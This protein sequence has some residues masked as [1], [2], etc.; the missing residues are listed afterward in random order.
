[1]KRDHLHKIKNLLLL[2]SMIKIMIFYCVSFFSFLLLKPKNLKLKTL[3]AFII[4]NLTFNIAL[5]QTYPVQISTQLIPPYSGYL[6]DYADPTAQNLKVI[7]QFND[8]TVPSY[9]LKLKFEIKGNG[10]SLVT[11]SIYNP[12]PLSLQPG[13]PL[14]LSGID[15]APYLSSNNLDFIGINQSQYEQRMALP[16]GYYSICVKAYDYYSGSPVQVS[17][18]ACAQGWFTLS[19]PPLLN[20]P[21]CNTVV[22]PLQPQNLLFSWTPVNL[23]SP[24]SA[25][26][27]SY[28]FELWEM[29]PDSTVNPNQLVQNTQPI[30]SQ[31]TTFNNL[32][33]GIADPPLN[34]YYKYAWRVRVIDGSGRDWFINNGFSQVCTFYYGSI[35]N[36]LG[37]NNG[38]KIQAEALDYTTGKATWT[39]QTIYNAYQFEVRKANTQN[40]FPYTTTSGNQQIDNLEPNNTY[41]C[42]VKGFGNDFNSEYSN[43]VQFTTPNA[44]T[45]NCDQTAPIYSLNTT[46]LTINKALPGITLRSGQFDI[47]IKTIEPSTNGLGWYKGSGYALMF[48]LLPVPVTF[49]NVFIDD[50]LRHQQGLIEAVTQG[51]KNW[52]V[53]FDIEDAEENA[54][55]TEGTLDSVY[56][57]G[58]Q[59]CYTTIQNQTPVC[60]TLDTTNKIT[61]IR[62][63]DGN[64]YVVNAGPPPT[65][66]GPTNYLNTSNDNLAASDTL[67]VEFIASP[68]Q[69]FGF[70]GKEYAAFIEGYEC[71]KLNNG[72]NYFVP[73]KS[74]GINQNDKVYA[75]CTINNLVAANLSFKTLGGAMLTKT[76]VNPTVFEITNIPANANCIYAWYN[77][78]KIGKLNVLSLNK[79]SKKLVLVPV[80]NASTLG[81]T[82][83]GLNAIYKQAN[84]TFTITTASN[85][86]FNLGNDGLQEADATLLKKYSLEM[87]ALRDAY[88]S[89]NSNYDKNAYYVFVVPNFSIPQLKGYMVRGRAVGFVKA[90][91]DAKTL[92][93]ELAHGAFGL[94]HTFPAIKKDSSNNLLDDANGIHLVKAQWAQI[95]NPGVIFNWLDD[96]EDG[97][98]NNTCHRGLTPTGKMFDDCFDQDGKKIN[99]VFRI[100]QGTGWITSLFHNQELYNWSNVQSKYVNSNAQKQITVN[101]KQKPQN[102]KVN[103]YRINA[104]GCSYQSTSIIWTSRD[105]NTVGDLQVRI[106]NKLNTNTL[107]D[108]DLFFNVKNNTCGTGSGLEISSCPTFPQNM[109]SVDLNYLKNN[110]FAFR[111]TSCLSTLIFSKRMQL[112]REILNNWVVTECL[113]NI[114][115]NIPNIGNCYEP[116]V[117]KL[118]L[119]TPPADEKKILDSLVSQNL[120]F[121]LLDK[122]QYN[123]FDEVAKKL[124]KWYISYYPKNNQA[125]VLE[126]LNGTAD[127]IEF[128]KDNVTVEITSQGI[129]LIRESSPPS[130]YFPPRTEYRLSN[131]PFLSYVIVSFKDN[132]EGYTAGTKVKMP[133]LLALYLF[134][135]NKREYLERNAKLLLDVGMLA[136]GAY[137]I[138]AAYEA[139]RVG[140]TAYQ[141]YIG[142]KAVADAGMSLADVIINDGLANT[143]KD[144]PEGIA[145]L[146]RWNKIN[147]YYA[148]GSISTSLL[149]G[150]IGKY[151]NNTKIIKSENDFNK[152]ADEFEGIA[153]GVQGLGRFIAK[154]GNE[155]KTHLNGIV[156]KPIGKTYT[157]DFYRSLSKSSEINYGALPNQ[158]T[159]HYIYSSWGRYDLPGEENAMYLSKTVTGNQT[160]LVPHYGAWNDFSTYKYENIQVDNL[161]DITNDAVRQQLGTEFQQ[162]VKISTDPNSQVAKSIMYEYTNEIANWA[163]KNGFNGLIVPGARG[164]QNYENI[165]LFEQTYINQILQGKIAVPVKK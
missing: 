65:V 91:S 41:E 56:I 31:A 70:D 123:T 40:W 13:Q 108:T 97:S 149:E 67:K 138:K 47:K 69:N 116:L 25:F 144:T 119:S 72:K 142:T 55:Y 8:F 32:N 88:K 36:T 98:L 110:F 14:L 109:S 160:E 153:L 2:S 143:W 163:R 115:P 82:Q 50:K 103:I 113:Q 3:L 161:L 62:D 134:N 92:A 11:K 159:D 79:V 104:P 16:E 151:C 61:V 4:Y 145:R 84:T 49:S 64:Q 75:S 126:K 146:E 111:S 125:I 26:N 156:I 83:Q 101:V 15:I 128:I 66:T 59:Y 68:N 60:T 129:T 51:I 131:L 6:P 165:I 157:G 7:L 89:A 132:Y 74:I 155:L 29:R 127:A 95:Q 10:F 73:N 81:I 139:Y 44:P 90:G 54:T 24:N 124:A 135:K 114:N 1:M 107:W 162:L 45:Y 152:L 78:K 154:S 23:G 147:M 63:G 112:I 52:M 140:K 93:H 80:N 27:T 77:N 106:D 158:M 48:G 76:S 164:T 118:I 133:T 94:E 20:L 120:I 34:L 136:L 43:I 35:S 148:M 100:T 12:P 28:L 22:T 141:I 86:T 121:Q 57:N 17:N 96:E 30:F 38:L 105:E 87:R 137:E 39:L 21:L 42:R 19:N 130:Q 58:N 71:I 122:T 9:N 37:N 85:F 18:E 117:Y 33:Y 5:G 99:P 102:N 150:A 53:Q 46:P